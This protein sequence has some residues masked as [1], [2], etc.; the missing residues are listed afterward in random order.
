M[1]FIVFYFTNIYLTLAQSGDED[2]YRLGVPNDDEDDDC[3]EVIHLNGEGLGDIRSPGNP[4]LYPDDIDCGWLLIAAPGDHVRVAFDDFD[5]EPEQNCQYDYI[6]IYDGPDGTFPLIGRFC[7]ATAPQPVISTNRHLF[8]TFHSDGS[9]G[10][11]G[12]AA[13]YAIHVGD[14]D[15]GDGRH[16][17]QD[18]G[19]VTVGCENTGSDGFVTSPSYPGPYP[20]NSNCTYVI[21]IEQEDRVKVTFVEFDLEGYGCSFDYLHVRDGDSRG[22]STT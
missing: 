13:N 17:N 1:I 21:T 7:G 18:I 12:F 10:G 4:E 11:R 6:S 22:K 14:G 15:H 20:S 16:N 19:V 5:I 9:E 2:R 8:I 3:F